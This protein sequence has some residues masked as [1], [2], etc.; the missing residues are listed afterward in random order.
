M[1]KFHITHECEAALVHIVWCKLFVLCLSAYRLRRF[2]T[3]ARATSGLHF[4]L[5]LCR[6]Q[7]STVLQ[8][9]LGLST[10]A[11]VLWGGRMLTGAKKY[12]GAKVPIHFC[13]W[14][15]NFLERNFSGTKV[16]RNKSSQGRMFLTGNF[17]S[18]SESTKEWKGHNSY[19]LWRNGQPP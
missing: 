1:P 18:R 11:K 7:V 17:R 9:L 4:D 6:L 2:S 14:N 10:G 3:N 15:E 16:P 5:L 19:I 12:D 13:S 8:Q